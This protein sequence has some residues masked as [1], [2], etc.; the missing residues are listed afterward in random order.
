MDDDLPDDIF[1]CIFRTLSAIRRDVAG[2]V[3]VANNHAN[4]TST[5]DCHSAHTVPIAS[6]TSNAA[7]SKLFCFSPHSPHSS[8]T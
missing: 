7:K 1:F 5:N 4:T 3:L 2:G 8:T 6:D